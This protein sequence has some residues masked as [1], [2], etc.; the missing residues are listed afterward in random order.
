MPF[1]SEAVNN[2]SHIVHIVIESL[3]FFFK[4]EAVVMIRG[5]SHVSKLAGSSSFLL[6]L[7]LC[8]LMPFKTETVNNNS[9]FCPYSH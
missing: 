5:S 2:D 3:S 8:G 4:A 1:K 9:H 6:A 7:A